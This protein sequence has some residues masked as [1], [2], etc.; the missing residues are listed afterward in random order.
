M[1]LTIDKTI[2]NEGWTTVFLLRICFLVPHNVANYAFGATSLSFKDFALGS[3]GI[4]PMAV[5]E[6]YTGI[7]VTDI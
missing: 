6:I 7:C 1:F 2:Q 3:L 4:V 5:L